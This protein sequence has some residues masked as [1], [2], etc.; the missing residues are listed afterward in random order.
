MRASVVPEWM[1]NEMARLT[2]KLERYKPAGRGYNRMQ[3]IR[4]SKSV[5]HMLNNPLPNSVPSIPQDDSRGEQTATRTRGV[6]SRS[7]SQWEEVYPTIKF[8]RQHSNESASSIDSDSKFTHYRNCST[9]I[10]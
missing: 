4:L 9:R 6:L 5:T 8:S 1:T 3:S 10:T 2:V 7:E